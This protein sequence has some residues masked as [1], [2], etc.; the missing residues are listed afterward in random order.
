MLKGL[1][2]R[3]GIDGDRPPMPPALRT[4]LVAWYNTEIQK[5][6][7]FDVIESYANDWSVGWTNPL[8]GTF[9]SKS[10]TLATGTVASGTITQRFNASCPTYTIKYTDGSRYR[11]FSSGAY[12]IER[13][14]A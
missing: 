12:P 13:P 8:T 14:T 11:P 4:A 10:I 9:T 3:W 2:A 5:A 7:N 1:T 6:T